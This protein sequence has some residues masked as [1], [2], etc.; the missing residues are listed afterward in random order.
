MIDRCENPNNK[1]WD[2]YG[3]RGIKVCRRW[4]INFQ[5][6]LADVGHRPS[7]KHSIERRDNDGNYSPANCYWATQKEQARNT[8]RNR[9]VLLNGRTMCLSEAAE[10]SGVNISTAKG[11]LIRGMSDDEA[12]LRKD[13]RKVTEFE[14]WKRE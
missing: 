2:R 7:N 3:G 10:L 4:R 8:C 6:F 1:R 12:F 5:T 13:R 11:R 9:Q 14:M